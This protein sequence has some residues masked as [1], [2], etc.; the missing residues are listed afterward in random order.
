M[1]ARTRGLG[2]ALTLL[3]LASAASPAPAQTGKG[4]GQPEREPPGMVLDRVVAVVNE[5]ALTLSEVQE[6]G[7]PV[8]R[9][10]FQDFVG[11]ERE[12][13]LEEAERRLLDDLI[14]RRLMYQAAKREGML[15]SEAEIQGALE[16]LKR[17]NNVTDEAQFRALLKAEGLTLEQVRRS[18]GERLAIGRLLARQVRSAIILGEDE[19]A[20]YYQA[21]QDKY[22][23]LPQAEIRH[24]L[25]PIP[26][27][28][29]EAAVRAQAEAARAKI[30]EGAE[31]A[32]VARQY[33]DP[34]SAESGGELITVHRGELA[35]EIEAAAFELPAGGVSP[36]IRTEAGYHVIKVERV[37]AESVTPFAEV[38][39][40]IR[41]Q[42]F[43]EKFEA[44]RKEWLANLRKNA[45]IQV[46]MQ[47]K[48]LH[49]QSQPAR[50]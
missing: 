29:D 28:A 12:R 25:F 39:E 14:D 33:T 48:D 3:W 38:R 50:P 36:V 21:H 4:A 1:R 7:Q 5:E 15:P 41:D 49:A 13:R 22:R 34:S 10:I 11:A 40:A 20:Q 23:R 9:K 16:E 35:P 31:F 27:G 26:P 37:Q 6:E 44:K 43:Q 42:L 24:I 17:T 32:H 8:V 30:V 2:V 47:P 18:I 19:L 45:F 46:L